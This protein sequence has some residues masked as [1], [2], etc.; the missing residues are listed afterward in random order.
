MKQMLDLEPKGEISNEVGSHPMYSLYTA[1]LLKK[2]LEIQIEKPPSC[3]D[4]FFLRFA[5]KIGIGTT[6]PL[7]ICFLNLPITFHIL[8]RICA[9]MHIGA[10]IS[11]N[12]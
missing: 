12:H 5:H 2:L 8:W 4:L 9:L 7:Y 3:L 6:I 1:S 11:I 10:L